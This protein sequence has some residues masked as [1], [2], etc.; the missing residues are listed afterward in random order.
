MNGVGNG[1]GLLV[2]SGLAIGYAPNSFTQL[3]SNIVNYTFLVSPAAPN[4]YAIFQTHDPWGATVVKTAITNAG[5]TFTVFTPAQL[6]GFNFNDYRVIILNWDDHFLMDFITTYNAAIP[7][8]QT[9]IAGGGVVWMQGAIQGTPSDFYVM[10]FGGE[11]IWFLSP[12]DWIVDPSSPMV[13]GVPNPIVG[14]FASHVNHLGL[15]GNAHIVVRETDPS[16][17]SVLYDL[18]VGT[19]GPSPTPTPTATCTPV[20]FVNPAP[21][22]I[23]DSGM[24]S[25]Y[26]S[27]IVV[28]AQGTIVKVTVTLSA[29]LHTLPDDLDFLLVGPGG[30][31]AIIWSDA[32]GELDVTGVTV[33]LDD[34]AANPLP[35]SAQIVSGTYRPANYGNGDSWPPPAPTPL[36]G[37]ALSIFNGTNPNGTWSLYLVDDA[38][39]SDFGIVDGGWSLRITTTCPSPTP[40]P[41]PAAT[42]TATLTPPPSPTPTATL[43]PTPTSTMTPQPSPSPTIIDS[44][45]PTPTST[46]APRVTPSPRP[47]PTPGPRP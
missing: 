43:T 28:S 22:F 12:S 17:P 9:Y 35:D 16:G 5:H 31:N 24:A 39:G 20:F 40:T 42:P 47:R 13:A 8:L 38:V 25:P 4:D 33:T 21:I 18:R 1:C 14:K 30:Q 34:D 27:N 46:P 23:P 15:S 37:S 10:P 45:T 6:A 11:A 26:P 44:P 29:I 36:G 41:T 32:G 2:G 3:A 19:C 7:A